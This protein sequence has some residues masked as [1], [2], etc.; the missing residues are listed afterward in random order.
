ML[1]G[2][3]GETGPGKV[4]ERRWHMRVSRG[5]SS[6]QE[7]GQGTLICLSAW[8]VSESRSNTGQPGQPEPMGRR[9]GW[10]EGLT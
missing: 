9:Q 7:C 5:K 1:W 6:P 8:Y 2:P 10:R 3:E 4:S